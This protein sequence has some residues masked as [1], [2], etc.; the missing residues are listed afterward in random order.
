MS[1]TPRTQDKIGAMSV[2]PDAEHAAALLK[3]ERRRARRRKRRRT[4]RFGVLLL[5]L[6][7]LIYPVLWLRGSWVAV[8]DWAMDRIEPA[9]QARL[10]PLVLSAESVQFG[11]SDQFVPRL[12]MQNA[13]LT[14]TGSQDAV[15]WQVAKL[16]LG[17]SA[18]LRGEVRI[19]HLDL[20]GGGLALRRDADGQFQ[21]GF[22]LQSSQAPMEPNLDAFIREADRWLAQ[23]PF[24]ELQEL[25]AQNLNLRYLD[26]L[27][28]QTWS[29]DGGRVTLSQDKDQIQARADMAILTGGA[30]LSTISIAIDRDRRSRIGTITA[31]MSSVQAQDLGSQGPALA[32][33]Q[34]LNAPLSG[35]L[36]LPFDENGAKTLRASLDIGA[37]AVQP[38]ADALPVPFE[39]GRAYFQFDPTTGRI[40]VDDL[41]ISGDA[42]QLTADGYA[43]VSGD[44]ATLIGHLNLSQVTG[45]LTFGLT[46][47]L[48]IK[49]ASL[50]F[51]LAPSPFLAEIGHV[52]IDDGRSTASGTGRVALDDGG[53]NVALDLHSDRVDAENIQRY[54]PDWLSSKPRTWFI[55]N[56][57][58]GEVENAHLI[59]R[60]SQGNRPVTA[61]V[62][63]LRNVSV[64]YLPDHPP[65]LV[66]KGVLEIADHRLG[67]RVTQGY[68]D[69]PKLGRLDAAGTEFVIANMRQKPRIGEI[70]LSASGGLPAMMAL[71]DRKPLRILDR[72]DQGPTFLQG[73]GRVQGTIKTPLA[74]G[75]LQED[76]SYSIT[77]I[78]QGV[79]TT[80][81][82]EGRILSARNLTLNARPGEIRVAGQMAL[83]GV[84]ATVNWSLV[85]GRDPA[86]QATGS[87]TLDTQRLADLG[88][89]LPP[90]L[91]TGKTRADFRLDMPAGVPPVLR[92]T[93]QLEGLGLTLP[94]HSKAP[95]DRG[96]LDLRV[97]LAQPARVDQMTLSAPGLNLDGA[98]T[99]AASGGF[100]SATFGAVRLG[101]WLRDA[102]VTLTS[103][104]KG[105]A[106]NIA[107]RGG[108][109]DLRGLPPG[110]AGEGGGSQIDLRLDRVVVSDR[111]FL[112]DA[113]GVLGTNGGLRGTVTGQFMG[114]TPMEAVLSQGPNGTNVA[115]RA[116]QSGAV[117]AATGFM[118]RSGG[119]PLAINLRARAGGGYDGTF[120][121]KDFRLKDGPVVVEL[122]SAVSIVGLFEQLDG[123]G[124]LFSEVSGRFR[125]ANDLLTI[126]E[127]TAIGPSIGV[128]IDGFW[129]LRSKAID[130]QG[131]LS[132]FY[133]VN[134]LGALV[135]RGREGLIGINFSLGG[136]SDNMQIGVN[137]LSVLTPGIFREIFRRAPPV[138]E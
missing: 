11:L 82:V 58:G 77:G 133:V 38:R 114:Q 91:V 99:L 14:D 67:A 103:Q 20:S 36:R 42:L 30:E 32:W 3:A 40:T 1:L 84:P 26:E 2:E 59:V 25:T 24:G 80:S 22:G 119:G 75:V 108:R 90:G 31:E 57:L 96:A 63:E 60:Y 115:I 15:T 126:A 127:A 135:S 95:Q 35:T 69:V 83:D 47:P 112:Q 88:V 136:R 33:L 92:V 17:R 29:M 122:L 93:S 9:I 64:R 118:K 138:L 43:M 44:G 5:L 107:V 48:D 54:W 62:Q 10:H 52:Y 19:T 102:Q 125:L 18:A 89:D 97:T 74:K 21:L 45:G 51:K 4:M 73:Q 105:Q 104:G 120:Q 123:D 68:V 76:V 61:M 16:R 39:R 34:A 37:G 41:Q 78:G 94:G 100:Q 72:I 71:L 106:P 129:N 8:P 134:V 50:D 110:G 55:N 13:R 121:A 85:P 65:L 111:Y 128:S 98:V 109:L 66:E 86:S 70:T 6:A 46:D 81:L 28:D 130:I 113:A 27:N 53:W 132:P 79:T 12:Q 87:L 23:G 7:V 116:P 117:V 124:L 56:I 131:T 137:P 101:T 49:A